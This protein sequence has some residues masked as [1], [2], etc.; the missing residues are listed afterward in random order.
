MRN[1]FLFVRLTLLTGYRSK[2]TWLMAFFAVLLVATGL[3]AG[4]FSARQPLV[5]AADVALSGLHFALLFLT[6]VWV[7]ELLLKDRDRK[8]TD[9]VLAYPV[10]RVEYLLGKTLGIAALLG[11]ATL[12]LA[13]PVW[14]LGH[15]AAWGYPDSSRPFFGVQFAW[16]V[17]GIWLESLV[18]LSFAVCIFAVS[19]T[20][21]IPLA[22]ALCFALAA[23]NLGGAL[24]FLL[25]NP[26]ASQQLKGQMLPVL[27]SIRWILP[28]LSLLDWR[29]SFLYDT[30]LPATRWLA[31]LMSL[32]YAGIL[33]L[34]ALVIF[35]HR[36]IR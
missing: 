4:A 31:T 26:D 22:A 2:L 34:T 21:Y 7:Q 29:S 24:D 28:D 35:R 18:V 10:D 11:L 3:L 9:W 36:Q 1:S 20:P 17:W 19:A 8:T 6:L 16:T 23:R 27:K 14:M 5:V 15:W 13:I 32:A 33:T 25:F 30:P 12:I